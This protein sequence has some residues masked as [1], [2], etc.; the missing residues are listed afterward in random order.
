[1]G[2][3]ENDL[4]EIYMERA[5]YLASIDEL[6]LGRYSG[7]FSGIGVGIPEPLEIEEASRIKYVQEIKEDQVF[8]SKEYQNY[9][10]LT[11]PEQIM[12]KKF[13]PMISKKLQDDEIDEFY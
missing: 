12:K 6:L 1:M 4:D 2:V 9:I 3:Y 11:R 10:Q 7:E 5:K 8:T 13:Q